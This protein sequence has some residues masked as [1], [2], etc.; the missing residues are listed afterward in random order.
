[1]QC[2]QCEA[3]IRKQAR[4][5]RQLTSDCQ[6]RVHTATADQL[7]GWHKI[8]ID[9]QVGCFPTIPN[10]FRIQICAL[11]R[12]ACAS[13][14]QQQ[15]SR[16]TAQRYKNKQRRSFGGLEKLDRT[17]KVGILIKTSLREPNTRTFML[18][19]GT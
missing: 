3:S 7:R 14:H 18:D 9:P 19:D 1:M 10:T 12:I 17:S 4:T 11:G 6:R 8:E 5:I 2:V 16:K 13:K 15:H